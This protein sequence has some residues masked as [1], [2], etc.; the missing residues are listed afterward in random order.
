MFSIQNVRYRN[1]LSIASLNFPP[2]QVSC[3]LGESGSGKTTLL[4][5]L[6]CIISPDEGTIKYNGT[7][8][9]KIDPI[10]LRRQAVM[11]PQTPVISPGNIE[12]NLNLGLLLAEQPL[13]HKEELT[14]FLSFV[15][16]DKRL[17]EP[18][19]NLSGGEKQRLALARLLLMA[20]EVMLLDEPSAALDEN[21][22]DQIIARVI[23]HAQINQ[24]TVIMITHTRKIGLRFADR[25]ITLSSGQVTN[26]ERNDKYAGRSG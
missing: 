4:K 5:L 8:I 26:V 24:Q 21:L 11:L 23:E 15:K 10:G 2:R 19:E 13:K 6:N 18:A 12:E 14:A 17:D 16:L 9:D 22:E 1:I 20:P 25:L 3:I 7:P